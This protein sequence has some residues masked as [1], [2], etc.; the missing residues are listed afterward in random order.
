MIKTQIGNNA[1]KILNFLDENQ[2]S[3][4]FEIE[5]QLSMQR[6]D[7]LMALGWLACEDR[8]YFIGDKNDCKI[9]IIEDMHDE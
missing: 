6:Q 2:I 9:M 7:I 4:V 3:S 1:R 8:I 5:K